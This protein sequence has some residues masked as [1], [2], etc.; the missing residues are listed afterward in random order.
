MFIFQKNQNIGDYVVV[1]PH[2]DSTYAQTYRV[3]DKEG[4]VKFLK[5]IFKEELQT[6]Q[7]DKD[8][9]IIER[10]QHAELVNLGGVYTELYET[11]FKRAL[12]TVVEKESE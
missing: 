12:E 9:E 11:Q 10:G 8:G 4:K 6:F 2:K 1:F 3:K 5:L 7:Y